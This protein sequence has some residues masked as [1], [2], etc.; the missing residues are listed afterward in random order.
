VRERDSRG[1]AAR[2]TAAIAGLCG[3]AVAQ[4][5]A[6]PYALVQGPQVA[7]VCAAAIAGA[8]GLAVALSRARHDAGRVAWRGVV[9][10]GAL[11]VGGWLATRA[12][13][14]PGVPEDAGRWTSG[15]GLASAGAAVILLALGVAGAGV[16]RG[17]RALHSLAAATAVGLALAPAAAVA[18]VGLG[19]A[20]AH[21]HAVAA[22]TAGAHAGHASAPAAGPAPRFRPGFGGHSGH[23]VYANT[24]RAHLPPWALALALGAAAAFVSL[25][26]RASLG[27]SPQGVWLRPGERH[28]AALY[29]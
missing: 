13:A 18:F 26:P 3:L 17:R 14:V 16:P 24:S 29:R 10:L 1:E 11:V 21:H 7:A 2:R 8:L 5:A 9:A 12:I 4:L 28:G 23:Y 22:T 19:P 6:L 15:P 20:P 25:A 27:G